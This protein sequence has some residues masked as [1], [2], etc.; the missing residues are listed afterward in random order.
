MQ[1]RRLAALALVAGVAL[2]VGGCRRGMHQ[3]P[4]AL[5]WSDELAPGT[6][7]HLHTVS[8]DVNVHGTAERR[9]RVQGIK[10]WRRG[11]ERDVKFVASRSGDD[12][13]V[14]AIWVRRGGRCGDE[15]YGPRPPRILA[16]FSLFGRRTDMHAS[17]EVMLPAGV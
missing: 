12:V 7:V 4:D 16:M 1:T 9:A 5:S 15:R 13:Y 10:R 3:V 14:C 8:G 2:S 6:T 17:F 11:R